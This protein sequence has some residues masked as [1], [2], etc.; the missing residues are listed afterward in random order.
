L[1]G[2]SGLS[3]D[4]A[5]LEASPDLQAQE[6]IA[7]FC[8]RAAGAISAL[9]TAIGGL[10]ALVFTAGIGENSARVRREICAQLGWMGVTLNPAANTQ[11]AT[12]LEANTSGVAVL[13]NP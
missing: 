13:R 12:H 3:S 4:M 10:D 1:L 8:Y 5:V 6:A 11:G 2:V 7:L 9:A